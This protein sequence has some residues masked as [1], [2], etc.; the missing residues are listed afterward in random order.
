MS[1]MT[2]A[3]DVMLTKNVIERPISVKHLTPPPFQGRHSSVTGGVARPRPV[4]PHPQRL[5]VP[6]K[7]GYQLDVDGQ[8]LDDCSLPCAGNS[9][10]GADV[11]L[12]GKEH[13]IARYLVNTHIKTIYTAPDKQIYLRLAAE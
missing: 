2:V 7:L 12:N 10:I 5:A 11:F 8:T 3:M 9:G 1:K 4:Y 13:S 6:A